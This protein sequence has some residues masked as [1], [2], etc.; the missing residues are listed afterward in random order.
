MNDTIPRHGA[1]LRTALARLR[2]VFTQ[3]LLCTIWANL[4]IAGLGFF[5]GM[6]AARSLGPTVRGQLAAIQIWPHF[7]AGI[8]LLGMPEALVYLS[9]RTP[10]NSGGLLAS[11]VTLAFLSSAAV[12]CVGFFLLPVLL[13]AQSAVTVRTA[14]TYL[15]V[16]PLFIGVGMFYSPLRGIG[17]LPLWNLL[18]L[19]APC[20]WLLTLIVCLTT[21]NMTPRRI[22]YCNFL[23]LALAA[24][25]IIVLILRRIPGPYHI[26]PALWRPLL[27]YGIPCVLSSVA[28]T[29]NL[30]LDQILMAGLLPSEALGL[31]VAATAWSGIANPVVS[32]FGTVLLPR[33]AWSKGPV[34]RTAAFS[35]EVRS[36]G[37]VAAIIGTLV[38]LATPVA[39][40]LIFG[41]AFAP[42][43]PSGVV[44][45]IAGTMQIFN[46]VVEDGIRGL[47]RP[48]LVLL[49]ELAGLAMMFATLPFLMRRFGILGAAVSSLLTYSTVTIVLLVSVC[50]LLH[51]SPVALLKPQRGDLVTRTQT[52]FAAMRLFAARP[53]E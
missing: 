51:T 24:V 18:R 22:V 41:K 36:A 3:P 48:R 52:L 45:A 38:A 40:P 1:N 44:L 11:A 26:E 9:A 35:R 39:I 23:L 13:H 4:F 10:R 5:T 12:V 47:G 2:F 21:S 15:A 16:I 43:I 32:A 14:R 8:A 17:Q 19:L 28:L 29:L 34:E 25:T 46:F 7:L 33:L 37:V 30:R 20:A 42:A 27:G 49:T 50:R 31:Y 6:I 53:A